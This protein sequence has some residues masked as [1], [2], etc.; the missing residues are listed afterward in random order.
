MLDHLSCLD[1]AKCG[2][3]TVVCPVFRVDPRESLT[4]RGKMYLLSLP[5]AE[6][7][8]NH[9]QDIFSR[10]LLCG[11]CEQVCSRH[12]PITKLITRARGRFPLFSGSHG[13][14]K[15][16]ARKAL[17]SPGLL[18]GLVRAGISLKRINALPA[19]SG[20]RL[21][22]G[23]MEGPSS[24][25]PGSLAGS[26]QGNE[27]DLSYFSGCLA[28]YLQP[29]VAQATLRL[30]GAAG[31]SLFIPASQ[32]CCG[33]A[34]SAAGRE[35]E[36]RHL[37]WRNILAFAGSAGPI[38]T[39]CA[40]CSS[41]LATYPELFKDDREKLQKARNFV[42]RVIEFSSFFLKQPDLVLVAR[43]NQ[44][45]FYH[46]P[47]HLRFTT[48]GRK[49]PRMLMERVKNIER[50]ESADGPQ[51]CGQGG[52]FQL[53]CPDLSRNIFHKCATT[54]LACAPDMVVTTC[55]GCLMQWQQGQVEND[56][57]VQVRHLAIL[58]ADCLE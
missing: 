25:K 12:L 52:L 31:H 1:C 13:V 18:Q 38:I 16:L 20:L 22:L 27:A 21:K 35:E 54:A 57:P 28:R 30:A 39:S 36:S 51:C 19:H 53:G 14:Q 17:S 45:V 4:A 8:S 41:H 58:L 34:A 46:D 32:G 33:L 40:S 23:L 7:P 43:K 26:D 9:F 6:Q 55:S 42:D 10:C 47:C 24:A 5:F 48:S 3:C 15:V 2:A 49:N 37:A 29:S 44:K 11:A 50:V 56:L